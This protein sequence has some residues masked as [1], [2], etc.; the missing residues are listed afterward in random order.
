MKK[1]LRARQLCWCGCRTEVS[2][3][4]YFARGHDK[5]AE[6]ALLAARYDGAVP[7]LLDEHGY[8]PQKSVVDDAV[9]RGEWERCPDCG[10]PGNETTMRNHQNIHARTDRGPDWPLLALFENDEY[11]HRAQYLDGGPNVTTQC[12][13]SGSPTVI[14][15]NHSV[16]C[17]E[18]HERERASTSP[19]AEQ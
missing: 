3:G 4:S 17:R 7:R 12:G 10:H 13:L 19:Q 6:A 16:L 14:E 5:L 15:P 8:G 11:G 2:A 1:P 18:C 9:Q